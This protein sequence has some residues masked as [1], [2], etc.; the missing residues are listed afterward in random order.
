MLRPGCQTPRETLTLNPNAR[1]VLAVNKQVVEGVRFTGYVDIKAN[2]VVLRNC[3]LPA[4]GYFAIRQ[5][6]NFGGLRLENVT[7]DGAL[8]G[9]LGGQLRGQIWDQLG[10]RLRDQLRGQLRDQL[11]QAVWMVGG[12]DSFWLAFYEAGRS[13]GATYPETLDRHLDAYI[14]YA[15]TCGVAFCYRDMAFTADRPVRLRFDEA[16]R[17]HADDGA[18]LAWSDGYGV[19]AWHGYRIPDTHHWIIADK[20]RLTVQAAMAERNAELR[21]IMLEIVGFERVAAELGAAVVDQD[22]NCGQPRRL[23]R[24]E[25]GGET[26][27][28]LH[29]V[30]GSLEPNGTRREF[31]LG[32]LSEARTCHEAVAMSY[33]RASHSYQEAGR[34]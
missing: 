32:A 19:Y 3:L 1:T 21:R 27:A 31:H 15:K 12:W 4:A 33:G 8:G 6:D 30:N 10:G 34:T 20:A 14:R 5:Y 29:V 25:V 28:I 26:L 17:L 9:Q 18:A 24:A 23:L 11:Y 13:V 16:R 2:D 22:V 7:V